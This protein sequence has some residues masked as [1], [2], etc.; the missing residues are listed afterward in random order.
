MSGILGSDKGRYVGLPTVWGTVLGAYIATKAGI[1]PL[2]I[3]GVCV[4]VA[5]TTLGHMIAHGLAGAAHA[6]HACKA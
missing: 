1:D 4:V 3:L 6:A 5:A 2:V